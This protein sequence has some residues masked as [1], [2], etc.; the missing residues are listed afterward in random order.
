MWKAGYLAECV[1]AAVF[2]TRQYPKELIRA[3]A[4]AGRVSRVGRCSE[5]IAAAAGP[6]C[7]P[8]TGE[9][10][11]IP[12]HAPRPLLHLTAVSPIFAHKCIS[13]S[14]IQSTISHSLYFVLFKI[15]FS[16]IGVA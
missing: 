3:N 10:R 6:T 15:A 13:F 14:A 11:L 7:P 8:P 16:V 9:G 5:K 4:D 1:A 2:L 12:D